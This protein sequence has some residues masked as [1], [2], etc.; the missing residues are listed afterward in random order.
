M[1]DEDGPSQTHQLG[2][3]TAT[4]RSCPTPYP[5]FSSAPSPGRAVATSSPALQLLL[6][7][8]DFVCSSC[9]GVSWCAATHPW[10]RDLLQLG[11]GR[12]LSK[13]AGLLCL[14]SWLVPASLTPGCLTKIA[15]MERGLLT[16]FFSFYFSFFFFLPV[17][18]LP[19]TASED[20]GISSY[21]CG[22]EALVAKYIRH[23]GWQ[24]CAICI[25]LRK[26]L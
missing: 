21:R 1:H 14:Q 12:A 9:L 13:P 19:Q 8:T 26:P 6:V 3:P 4:L 7:S 2:Q 16:F 22:I 15:A 17:L 5:R 11:V 10:E 24:C 20:P 18:K 25:N 23:G